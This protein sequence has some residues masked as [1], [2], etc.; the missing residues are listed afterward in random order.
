MDHYYAIC[1]DGENLT[2]HGIK[3]MKWGIR[4]YQNPDGSLTAAGRL[5]YGENGQKLTR[6]AYRHMLKAES[7]QRTYD[8]ESARTKK[9][10]ARDRANGTLTKEREKYRRD[11]DNK[12]KEARDIERRRAKRTQEY[13]DN[14][15]KYWNNMSTGKKLGTLI[16]YGPW[17]AQS[18]VAAKGH[19]YS[20]AAAAG[21]TLLGNALGGPIGNTVINN[22]ERSAYAKRDED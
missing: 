7:Y 16:L 4:R 11:A 17:G 19:G 1:R 18:Y 13:H 6:A 12:W 9:L 21:E 15:V 3:G 20:T 10:N 2:H 5:R 14:A 22:L 8:S